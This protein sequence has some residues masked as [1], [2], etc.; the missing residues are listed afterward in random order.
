MFEQ[1]LVWGGVALIAGVAL[2][3]WATRESRVEG[4]TT[5]SEWDIYEPPILAK[6]VDAEPALNTDIYTEAAL[7]AAAVK[8]A[9]AA[10]AARRKPAK[11][12]APVKAKKLVKA[13]K[14]AKK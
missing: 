14:K 13:T 11:R 5:L 4:Q 1:V 8:P 7:V 6:A 3:L 10:K 9:K 2:Y 12:K